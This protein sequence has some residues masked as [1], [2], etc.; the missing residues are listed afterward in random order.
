M[1][2]QYFIFFLLFNALM[3][4]VNSQ[5]FEQLKF[6]HLSSKEGLSQRSVID[7]F[8]DKKGYLW[9]ATRDGLNK[10]DGYTFTI[11]RHNSEDSKSLSHSWVT[12]IHE[13]NYGNL[14]VGTKDGL[15]KYNPEQ[16]NFIRYKQ[17][18]KLNSITHN[19]IW[20]LIQLESN[21]LWVA[22]S[23]GVN[24]IRIKEDS[25]SHFKNQKENTRFPLIDV[26]TRGFMAS[27]E[28]ELWI[29]TVEGINVFNP[30]DN[31]VTHYNYPKG[32][33]KDDHINNFP[34]LFED[35]YK[36]IWL[37]HEKGLAIFNKKQNVFVDYIFNKT[38]AITSAVRSICEDYSGN[39]WIGTYSGLYL[40]NQENYTLKNISHN[41]NDPKSLSQNSIYK[42]FRD[43]R[44]DMWIGTWAGGINY[45][46]K[47]Y[48]I[49]KQFSSGNSENMLNYEV[50]SAIVEDDFQNLWVGTE[51][52]G[53][54][55]YNRK[56]G[57]FT[58]YTHNPNNKNS[59]SSN[60]VKSIIKDYNGNLW[61]GTHDKGLNFLN[62]KERPFVFKKFNTIEIEGR[63][64]SDYRILSLFED[65]NQNIWIGTLTKGLFFHNVKSKL[66]Y[67]LDNTTKSIKTIVPSKDPNYL[68]IGGSHELEKVNINT[69]EQHKVALGVNNKGNSLKTINCIYIDKVNN[70]WIGTEGDGL[71][72]YNT[73]KKSTT[74]YGITHGL[75]NEVVYGVLE[76]EN[77]N[78]WVSTNKGISRFNIISKKIKNFD[79]SD[80]LQGNEFNYGAFLKVSSN[81]LM[82]GGVNGIT[83]FNPNQI[84]EN[85]FIPRIDIHNLRVNNN[86]FLK[87]TD[88][89]T[90]IT[91]KYNQNNFNIDFIGLSYSQSNKNQ[92]AYKL[93]N[94]DE[95]WNYIGNSRTATYTNIDQGN[96]IFR[97]KGSNNDSVWNEQG[98]LI[99]LS[100]LPAPWKTWWAFLIYAAIIATIL[101]YINIL[102][103]ARIKVKN[104]L[105]QE[106]NHRERIEDVNKLKLQ[107]FTN[108]SH[109]FRTPLTLIAAPLQQ[110]IEKKKGD[111]ETQN[112]LKS[113]YRNALTLLQ[114]IN[115]LL[116]FRKSEAGK[117]ELKVSKKN[118]VPF[119]ENVKLSFE[120]LAK[121]RNITYSFKTTK[122]T[123]DVWYDSIELK[124]V[125]VN[126]LSNAFKFTPVNGAITIIASISSELFIDNNKKGN[127]KI[128]IKDTGGGI[129][130]KEI[131]H[132]FDRFFQLG[133]LDKK[134]YGTGVGLSLTKDIVE[135]HH[136]KIQVKSN[137]GEGVTFI[138]LLPLGMA[139][140]SP[141]ET[142]IE[143]EV[144]NIERFSFY[145]STILKPEWIESEIDVKEAKFDESLPTILLVEDNIE[146]RVLIKKIFKEYFNIFEAE[147][148][149][150]GIEIAE[151]K[152]IDLI[153]SDVMM[154]VMGGIEM[155]HNLKTNIKTSHIP[156]IL[157]TARTSLKAQEKG[158][159]TGADIYITKPFDANILKLQ[160]NNLFESRKNMILKYKKDI[161][162]SP[163][164]I[165][166]TS[167]DEQFL[168]KA[169]KIV[170]ENMEESSF[171]AQSFT[172]KMSVSRTLLYNKI[173]ALTGQSLSE[174]VRTIRLKKAAQMITQTQMNISNIAY[175]LGFNDLKYFR[176]SF[177][178][179]YHVTP[180]QYRSKS[181]N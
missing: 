99:K 101:Y 131:A 34:T 89:T 114:L 132:I 86:P 179:I 82:F 145:E 67:K 37:G 100:V 52:G 152:P 47:S 115:Q 11:Y 120:E 66:F 65:K 21:V 137:H 83:Y 91:L 59:L 147:N 61:I 57:R 46:D 118:I 40:L 72:F 36:N 62:T 45:F 113:M 124:K 71:L 110:L 48:N 107:L 180:T 74:K 32:V 105:I 22:T 94:F 165:T 26:R 43:S 172:E 73:T 10:Y 81:E 151:T 122:E 133:A 84:N 98:D 31:K 160:V 97:V 168:E 108:I 42:I 69:R 162:L 139:H 39:L 63:A 70:Y 121:Q 28:G 154:P 56:T 150:K 157:L 27:K 119:I 181:K 173:K 142:T 143:N 90:Q 19:E 149:K 68:I 159:K 166:V 51:G 29:S 88:S 141:E 78:L 7:I 106:K 171:N 128:E 50:V 13:D 155:S 167:A 178:N 2:K 16:D 126:L 102:L 96:Y 1:K 123:I 177:K 138:V 174:F 79:V 77:N 64:I 49:F 125:I 93:E 170:E 127:I 140:F 9:F 53:I 38:K 60:N 12:A 5:E 35:S 117:L 4:N 20:D 87:I 3:Q 92:Y 14:W 169:F 148:G 135:L 176:N 33:T 104:E 156:I 6:K 146:I 144:E 161:I 163:K 116:D 55:F 109:D 76:D 158:Y 58:Y 54:N 17:N 18:S 25:I 85:T 103:A 8:Q 24:Q 136:G 134:R 23:N 111:K 164:E 153:I 95:D 30:R 130:K 44:G 80:G 112:Q 175:D 41:E 15:N 129:P 75:P